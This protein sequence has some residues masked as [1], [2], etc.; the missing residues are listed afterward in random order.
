MRGGLYKSIDGGT[1]WS[2][3]D[4]GITNC[5]ISAMA[6][7]PSSPSTVY[8]AWGSNG[9]DGDGL[10]KSTSAGTNWTEVGTGLPG[11]PALSLVLDPQNPN[12]LY[13]LTSVGL[14]RSTNSGASWTPAYSARIVHAFA[15]D[16]QKAGTIYAAVGG[17]NFNGGVVVKTVDAGIT[18]NKTDS[19]IKAVPILRLVVDP[20]NHGTIYAANGGKLYKTTDSGAH[21][22]P[23][24]VDAWKVVL[25]P[26]NSSVLYALYNNGLSAQVAKSTDGGLTWSILNLPLAADDS[27]VDLA[28]DPQQSS[29]VF[30]A[31][32][33][34]GVLK[35][36]DQ[37]ATWSSASSGLPQDAV[38]AL[39]ISESDPLT[40]YAGTSIACDCGYLGDGVF[41]STDGG[42]S[43]TAIN[44]GLPGGSVFLVAVDPRDA[45]TVYLGLSWEGGN[46]LFKSSDGGANWD[47][48]GS[49]IAGR[50]LC[51]FACD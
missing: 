17:A 16:P 6:I 10:Y 39:V 37:G 32:S 33:A 26:Q 42:S 41:K 47:R 20:Q 3:A 18:W 24:T 8:A 31:T 14:F 13:A 21:W 27:V 35:S 4:L 30:V 48:F 22:I 49:G 34:E 51:G 40:L 9:G 7:N 46:T 25:D 43:W 29:T 11:L 5:C 12:V 1:S 50:N 44:S 28:I 45:A 23:T 15:L 38:S 19:G 2:N 36:V